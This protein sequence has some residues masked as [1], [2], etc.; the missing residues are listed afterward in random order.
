[1]FKT[2]LISSIVLMAITILIMLV[3]GPLLWVVLAA[4]SITG[5]YEL[6]R[7]MKMEKS[8]MG[9][10]G[11]LGV[12][13]WG[14]AVA[15]TTDGSLTWGIPVLI[16]LFLAELLVFVLEYPKYHA[17][18]LFASVFG[19]I[20]VAVTLFFLYLTRTVTLYG[21]WL[22]WLVFIASWGSD[23]CAYAVGILIGKHK[24]APIL[25]PKKSIEGSI[26]GIFGAAAIGALFGYVMCYV[27]G[28]PFKLIGVF[29]LIG[30]VGSVISQIGDLAASGIKRCYDIKDY[31]KLIPGHGGI[32]DR[33]DS[34]IVTAPI[35]YY[36][37][38]F[39]LG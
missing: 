23:T 34:V 31:G 29:A 17:N 3:G 19:V 14:L 39:I 11:Y 5:V 13:W 8:S 20:Y 2:R 30:G 32:L 35:V 1:M 7:V 6:F 12:L 21:E 22:V 15:W 25:S 37:A 24:L 26:G 36:L 27:T 18:Q 16:L 33:F 4:V 38:M 10:I 28:E 9:Y